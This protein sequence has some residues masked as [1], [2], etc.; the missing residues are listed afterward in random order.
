MTSQVL[1]LR[2]DVVVVSRS[3]R[4]LLQ[5]A[6]VVARRRAA[7]GVVITKVSATLNPHF[8]CS[9]PSY[10]GSGRS[11]PSNALKL[12]R[13]LGHLALFG[14]NPPVRLRQVSAK[15]NPIIPG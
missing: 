8:L 13:R 15:P 14:G 6:R 9:R 2:G 4:V 12:S 3:R 1:P 10:E 11:L 5:D 7:Q